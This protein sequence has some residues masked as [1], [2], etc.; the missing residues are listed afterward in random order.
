MAMPPELFSLTG[1]MVVAAGTA[2]FSE[3][4]RLGAEACAKAFR[5]E[6]PAK[7]RVSASVDVPVRNWRR[8]GLVAENRASVRF[9]MVT[10]A[11][12]LLGAHVSQRRAAAWMRKLRFTT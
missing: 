12:G 3:P 1:S 8:L 11:S 9:T 6:V 2:T 5:G 4:P 7:A 10:G